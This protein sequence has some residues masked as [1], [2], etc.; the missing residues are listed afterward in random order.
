VIGT[1]VGIPFS[2]AV[3]QIEKYSKEVEASRMMCDKKKDQFNS[4]FRV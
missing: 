3:N 1:N 4:R 2:Q